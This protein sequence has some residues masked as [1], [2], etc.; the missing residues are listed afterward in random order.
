MCV[1][2]YNCASVG[3]SCAGLGTTEQIE[4]PGFYLFAA[5]ELSGELG[6]CPL[7]LC[8]FSSYLRLH[9]VPAAAAT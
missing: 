5:P 9:R 2:V 6:C 4:A 7:M 3:L 8:L 1:E